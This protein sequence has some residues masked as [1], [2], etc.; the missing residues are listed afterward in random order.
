MRDIIGVG[1]VEGIGVGVELETPNLE[2]TIEEQAD[3]VILN[4]EE[5]L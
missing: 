5:A 2:K 4:W 1:I 3:E